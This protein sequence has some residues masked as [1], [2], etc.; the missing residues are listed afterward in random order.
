MQAKAAMK[1]LASV[2]E[3]L[4]ETWAALPEGSHLKEAYRDDVT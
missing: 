3:S 1:W 4:W 2:K